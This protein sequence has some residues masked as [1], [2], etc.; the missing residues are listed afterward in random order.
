MSIQSEIN[1]IG[2]EVSTQTGL[3]AQIAA[4]LEGKAAGGGSSGGSVETCAVTINDVAAGYSVIH[5]TGLEN[6]R[7]ITK[8]L[9][10]NSYTG[11]TLDDVVCN[12]IVFIISQAPMMTVSGDA[13]L[14]FSGADSEYKMIFSYLCR[15]GNISIT[16]SEF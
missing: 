7:A 9:N 13:E 1:R 12:G 2:N 8:N 11:V 5:Y 14:F 4:A 10:N 3:I 6:G 15:S 16:G